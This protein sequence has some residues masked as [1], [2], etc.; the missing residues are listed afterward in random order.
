MER[1]K[2]S[3]ATQLTPSLSQLPTK[4]TPHRLVG[5][6]FDRYATTSRIARSVEKTIREVISEERPLT[7]YEVTLRATEA[8]EI[9]AR[10]V[11]DCI[12]FTVAH[13][14]SHKLSKFPTQ[15]TSVPGLNQHYSVDK[16]NGFPR[17]WVRPESMT[18]EELE[19]QI[20]KREV[21]RDRLKEEISRFE[22]LK[23]QKSQ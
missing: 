18:P 4:Y 11:S 8:L 15:P 1:V 3:S 19:N 20:K 21:Q 23:K 12:N 16:G 13:S 10:V 2:Q 17:E 6:Y 9:T 5:R 22:E 14:V 7:T